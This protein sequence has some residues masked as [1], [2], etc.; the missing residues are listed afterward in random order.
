MM[1][2]VVASLPEHRFGLTGSGV[3]RR[4]VFAAVLVAMAG[5]AVG[6]AFDLRPSPGPGVPRLLTSSRRVGELSVSIPR[7][8]SWYVFP[9]ASAPQTPGYAHVLTNFRPAHTT[10]GPLPNQVGLELQRFNDFAQVPVRLH[11]PL[12]LNQPW[13]SERCSVA[14]GCRYGLLRVS[15]RTYLV[16]YWSGPKAPAGDRAAI[17]SALS[18]IRPTH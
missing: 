3:G 9:A 8:L 13:F 7:G 2:G 6:I 17:L 12:S 1:R 4:W 18:S 15:G 10:S 5:S 14:V 16:T 11:L